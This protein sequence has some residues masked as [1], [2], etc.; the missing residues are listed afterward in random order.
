MFPTCDVLPIRSYGSQTSSS[1]LKPNGFTKTCGKERPGKGRKAQYLSVAPSPGFSGC[2]WHKYPPKLGDTFFWCQ[3]KD[4]AFQITARQDHHP[5][6][7]WNVQ[8]PD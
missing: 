4:D 1:C 7:N 5:L 6:R 8:S 2:R 3:K